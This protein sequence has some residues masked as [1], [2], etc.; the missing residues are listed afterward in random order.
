[1]ITPPVGGLLFVTSNVSRVPLS[2][3]TRELKPF[4]WAHGVVLVLLTFVPWLST[5]LPYAMGY[6]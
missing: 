5:W 4:L 3:L 1:M 2:D 6:K